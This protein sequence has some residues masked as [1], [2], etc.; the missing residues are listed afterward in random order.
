MGIMSQ[1]PSIAAIVGISPWR[2]STGNVISSAVLLATDAEQTASQL[3]YRV[4][5]LPLAGTLRLNANAI[6]ANVTTF[7]QDDINAGRLTYDGPSTSG[8]LTFG[9]SVNDGSLSTA[10]SFD[11][12]V[13]P[14]VLFNELKVNPH[15]N[16][17]SVKRYQ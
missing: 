13:V 16:H 9:F 14:N 7:T 8:D 11:L 4:T 3:V 2:N 6:V 10:G 12:R 15:G 5:S 1:A 17:E